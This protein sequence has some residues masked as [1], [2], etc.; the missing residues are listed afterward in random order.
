MRFGFFI[1]FLGI[2][3]ILFSYLSDY[4]IFNSNKIDEI[5]VVHDTDWVELIQLD[6]SLVLDLRYATINNFTGKKLYPCARAYL[7]RKVANALVEANKKLKVKGL[8]IKI[9]D[10]Y[11][12]LSIQWELWRM[13]S[14]P[15]YVADPR[16]GSVHNR[17]AA[18]DV[19]LVDAKG[20]ELDMGTPFDFFGPKAHPSYSKLPAKVLNNR[21][22]LKTTLESVGFSGIKTEWW[23]F[24]Y[25]K[26][27]FNLSNKSFVCM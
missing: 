17:G 16:K 5:K 9:W 19:T 10:A 24:S 11:R 12:P 20:K 4:Q 14:N 18:V 26:Q 3:L 22:L 27:N 23:H 6:K 1:C 2:N 8:R 7:R 13:Y 21:K 25:S 15:D